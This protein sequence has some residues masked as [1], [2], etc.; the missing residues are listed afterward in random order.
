MGRSGT[1]YKTETVA[2]IELRLAIAQA[3]REG[4]EWTGEFGAD[5]AT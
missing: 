1:V 2:D 4:E 5:R 3:E